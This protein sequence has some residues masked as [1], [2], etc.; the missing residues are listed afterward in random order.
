VLA[1]IEDLAF[2]ALMLGAET[3]VTAMAA[4]FP[5]DCVAMYA[6]VK[7]RDFERAREIHARLTRLWHALNHPEELLARL[8]FAASAQGCDAGVARSPY[9][10]LTPLA[11]AQ[12]ASALDAEGKLQPS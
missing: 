5:E 3:V 11:Q 2:V 4:V 8:K 12:V 6:A 7:T 10:A 1:A 9:D